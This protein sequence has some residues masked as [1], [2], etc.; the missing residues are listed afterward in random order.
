MGKDDRIS[1]SEFVNTQL[2]QTIQYK[3]AIDNNGLEINIKNDICFVYSYGLATIFTLKEIP[4]INIK[5]D[6]H[7]HLDGSIYID[8]FIK[9]FL[10]GKRYFIDEFKRNPFQSK[11]TIVDD[12]NN[13]FINEWSD[14]TKNWT[15]SIL[16]H[17]EIEKWGY[18][19]GLIYELEDFMDLNDTLFDISKK[20]NSKIKDSNRNTLE[21]LFSKPQKYKDFIIQMK[22][23]KVL[24]GNPDNFR[25]VLPDPKLKLKRFIC[26]IGYSLKVKGYLKGYND[27]KIAKALE[28][29]FNEKISKSVFSSA[30]NAFEKKGDKATDY[31]T[32]LFFL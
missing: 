23:N 5:T 13:F 15:P 2:K 17:K 4:A 12:L 19:N 21:E 1:I 18:Y 30:Q 26:C 9:G 20:N 3:K 11:E 29:T 32:S 27:S 14:Y 8:S 28:S 16:T 7:F 22:E 10:K 31:I 24:I 6:E 25:I